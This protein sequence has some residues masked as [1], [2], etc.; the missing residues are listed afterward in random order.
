MLLDE[1]ADLAGILVLKGEELDGFLD[2][3]PRNKLLESQIP[4]EFEMPA[5]LCD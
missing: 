3:I 4:A 2:V 1:V 5:W